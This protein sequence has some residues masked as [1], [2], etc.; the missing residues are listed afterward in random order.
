MSGL[1]NTTSRVH[2]IDAARI[3]KSAP[4]SMTMRIYTAIEV[5]FGMHYEAVTV[6]DQRRPVADLTR[7]SLVEPD[8]SRPL[9]VRSSAASSIGR[10]LMMSE[11]S[12]DT[13]SA[14]A[15][16]SSASQLIILAI[17]LTLSSTGGGNSS[18]SIF[19]R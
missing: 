15:N 12:D 4:L 1:T 16:N 11:R 7:L 18:R 13:R 14:R 17:A 10:R 19:D 3:E 8:P 6:D 2:R 5:L 9:V